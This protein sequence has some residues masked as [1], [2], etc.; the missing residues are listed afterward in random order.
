[1][2]KTISSDSHVTC[3][4]SPEEKFERDMQA[5]VIASKKHSLD[6]SI[7]IGNPDAV[8]DEDGKPL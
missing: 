6:T 3:R 7:V 2:L 1:M 4:L 8:F 5:A